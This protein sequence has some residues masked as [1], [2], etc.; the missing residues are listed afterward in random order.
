MIRPSIYL[1]QQIFQG[2]LIAAT[3]AKRTSYAYSVT[4]ANCTVEVLKLL[5]SLIALSSSWS[6]EGVTEHNT[7]RPSMSEALVYSIPALL[8]L[9]KNLL[10]YVIFL[11]VDPPS[12]QV[13]KNLN[14]ISTGVLYR[15]FLK[16]TLSVIQWSALILLAL[17]CSTAQ[18]TSDSNKVLSTSMSGLSL[19]I[20]MAI[21]SG[22]AGIYTELIMKKR[23]QRNINAQNALMYFFGVIFNIFAMFAHD[24]HFVT[25]NG[26]FHGYNVVVIVMIVNHALS[27]IAV[28]FVLKHANNIVKVYSTSVAMILTTAASILLFSFKPSLPFFLG[29][30]VVTVAVYLNYQGKQLN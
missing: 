4:S 3:K 5:F 20:L 6:K 1:K 14:I 11:Y 13:L 27:G 2:L 25:S 21:L 8:Y 30:S 12:Y 7:L 19:A 16:R 23:Q 22:G 9:V 18:L 24:A 10:Q 17:G 29:S 26:Y 15:I 28:S